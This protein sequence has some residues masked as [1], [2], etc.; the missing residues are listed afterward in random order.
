MLFPKETRARASVEIAASPDRVFSYITDPRHVKRWQPDIVE[1][2]PL[3]EGGLRA[4]ARLRTTVEEY[5]RRFDV[6]VRV[7]S[8][9]M[10]EHVAYDM[11]APTAAVHSEYRL[12]SQGKNTRVESTAVITPRAFG[13]FLLPFVRGMIRRKLQSRLRLLRDVVESAAPAQ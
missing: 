12:I 8:V 7:A 4:G 11:E 2:Q 5:G 10:N 3:P 9:A 6:E 13:R 1:S